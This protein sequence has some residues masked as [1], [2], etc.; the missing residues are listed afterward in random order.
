M[1]DE[2]VEYCSNDNSKG[3]NL[4][5]YRKKNLL[6]R[7]FVLHIFH[8]TALGLNWGL[9]G[10]EPPEQPSCFIFGPCFEN[11]GSCQVF[12]APAGKLHCFVLK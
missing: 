3:E 7:H 5:A 2:T 9:C 10:D 11:R 8:W 4:S 1:I 12:Y 6:R